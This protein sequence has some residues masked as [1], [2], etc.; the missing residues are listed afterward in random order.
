MKLIDIDNRSEHNIHNYD[1]N[2]GDPDYMQDIIRNTGCVSH[3]DMDY[4]VTREQFNALR[5]DAEYIVPCTEADEYYAE[6]DDIAWWEDWVRRMSAAMELIKEAIE[7]LDDTD[8]EELQRKIDN[9]CDCD[10]GDQPEAIEQ[11]IE[12]W[13]EEHK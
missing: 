8:S 2:P 4:P 7:E 6:A 12:N 11:A 1:G 10:L 5:T 3:G 13:K 9:A